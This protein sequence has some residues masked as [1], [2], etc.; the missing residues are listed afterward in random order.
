MFCRLCENIKD[1]SMFQS[2]K[3]VSGKT[4]VRT[5]CKSCRATKQRKPETQRANALRAYYK[6]KSSNPEE[7][8]KKAR[9]YR[10]KRRDSG[11]PI[12]RNCKSDKYRKTGRFKISIRAEVFRLKGFSCHYCGSK[13]NMQID[14]VVPV[15]KGG[16]DT[17]DNLVP[18]CRSCNSS[19]QDKDLKSWLK[20]NNKKNGGYL[21]RN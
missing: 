11:K 16:G 9:E 12:I 13:E 4:S 5:V 3:T 19:K 1:A 21:Y 17:I 2:Y 7:V 6:K 8:N 14:H 20:I 18:C 15:A 10:K